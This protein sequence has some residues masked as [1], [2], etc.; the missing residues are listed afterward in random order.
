MSNGD[1]RSRMKRHKPDHDLVQSCIQENIGM[2]KFELVSFIFF[3][4]F[5]IY[6]YMGHDD[7]PRPPSTKP[8]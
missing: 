2:Y 4:R 7:P 1:D 5:T 3:Y 6:S 8:L